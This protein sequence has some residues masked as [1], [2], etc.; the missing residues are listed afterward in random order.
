MKYEGGHGSPQ[1]PYCLRPWSIAYR[2]DLTPKAQV[3]NVFHVSQHKQVV[4]DYTPALPDMFK[5]VDL[6][7]VC[8]H[9]ETV[10]DRHLVKKGNTPVPQVLVKWN[11]FPP[12][13]ATWEDFYSMQAFSNFSCL[14][15]SNICRRGR[16]HLCCH[17]GLTKLNGFLQTQLCKH[18]TRREATDYSELRLESQR[19][20]GPEGSVTCG[21]YSHNLYQ[22]KLSKFQTE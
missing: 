21:L 20:W 11:H 19:V 22:L 7:S 3:H 4:P 6:S 14:G 18:W 16:C 5:S 9:P 10:L 15:T 12:D 17:S 8:L 1:S 13:A 2:L